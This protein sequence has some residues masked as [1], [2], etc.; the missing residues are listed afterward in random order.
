MEMEM[1]TLGKNKTWSVMKL[2]EGKKPMR[3]KWVFSIKY[4]AN[5]ETE[6]YKM[7]LI[8]KEYTQTYDINF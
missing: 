5:E 3:W 8:A 6:R 7:R 2:P 4:N 1:A